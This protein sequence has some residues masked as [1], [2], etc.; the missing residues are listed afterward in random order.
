MKLY[1]IHI[2]THRYIHGLH[3]WWMSMWLWAKKFEIRLLRV[4]LT[5]DPDL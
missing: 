5:L 2:H 3:G 1:D 4:A